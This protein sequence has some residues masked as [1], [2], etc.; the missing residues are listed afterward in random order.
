[1]V[2][3]GTDKNKRATEALADIGAAVLNG[4]MSTFLAVVVLF[5]SSSY[6]FNVLSTQFALT[7]GLGLLHGLVALPVLLSILGPKP[8]SSA[9]EP[10]MEGKDSDVVPNATSTSHPAAESSGG[11]SSSE[12]DND[13]QL[14]EKQSAPSSSKA[15]SQE[16]YERV[17]L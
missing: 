4:A 14:Q 3:G 12:N 15:E 6:V 11:S 1:M 5:F 16:L 7:V 13:L 2:K 17:S 9:E 10:A 8:F